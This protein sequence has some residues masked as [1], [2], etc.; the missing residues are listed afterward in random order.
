MALFQYAFLTVFFINGRFLIYNCL[1]VYLAYKKLKNQAIPYSFK[2]Q[3][4]TTFGEISK[5]IQKAIILLSMVARS[6]SVRQ[7][8]KKTLKIRLKVVFIKRL[9]KDTLMLKS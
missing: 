3:I 8:F 2:L 5:N 6:Q 9:R 7:N 1:V 4:K